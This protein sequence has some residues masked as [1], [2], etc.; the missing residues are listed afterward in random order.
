MQ[1][2]LER[3]GKFKATHLVNN[4]HK[5]GAMANRVYFYDVKIQAKDTRLTPEGYV[6]NN[7]LIQTYFDKRFGADAGPW[8]A[9]SCEKMALTTANDLATQLL[10]THIDTLCVKCTIHGSNGALITAIWSKDEQ[11]AAAQAV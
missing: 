7:E 8:E 3:S 4:H 9:I 5:C 11:I 1:L 2:E 6:M 10:D